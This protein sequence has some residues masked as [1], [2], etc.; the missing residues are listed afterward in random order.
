[1]RLSI[2]LFLFIWA[3]TCLCQTNIKQ[4]IPT[5]LS[6][7]IGTL[8]K[9]IDIPVSHYTGVPDVNIPIHTVRLGKYLAL[10][11]TLRY[12]MSGI[13]VDELASSVGLGWNLDA[14]GAII[15][16][17]Y[18]LN[19][20]QQNGWIRSQTNVS[21]TGLLREDFY[22]NE[23]VNY[24]A[25][26]YIFNTSVVNGHFD[27]QP[28]LFSYSIPGKS[29]KFFFTQQGKV[30]FM[31]FENSKVE[32][33]TSVNGF[34][35]FSIIDDKGVRYSFNTKE[36]IGFERNSGCSGMEYG[37][38]GQSFF[39]DK[40]V[41]PN[42]D[43]IEFQYEPYDY[44]SKI[45]FSETRANR[46]RGDNG[47][48]V[49]L[50]CKVEQNEIMHSFRLKSIKSSLGE[51]VN[52]SYSTSR[53]D[54]LGGKALNK[55]VSQINGQTINTFDFNY[56]YFLAS[57]SSSDTTLN[58]RLKLNSLVK[59]NTEKYTFGYNPLNLPHR[60]SVQQDYWGYYNGLLNSST[61]TLLPVDLNNNFISGAN[62]ETD[63]EAK[64]A[65]TL[66]RITYPTGGN[67]NF[68]LESNDI[69]NQFQMT[70]PEQQGMSFTPLSNELAVYELNVPNTARSFTASWDIS[71]SI[72]NASV[73]LEKG[74]TLIGTYIGES[75]G[76]VD[77]PN[78]APGIYQ[79]KFSYVTD[80]NDLSS[81]I[82]RINWIFDKTESVAEN[83]FVGGLRIKQINHDTN[84]GSPTI[85]KNYTY[86]LKG[87]A[88]S[89]GKT[90]YT[91]V[92][93]YKRYMPHT[94]STQPFCEYLQQSSNS[95]APLSLLSGGSAVYDYI[96]EFVSNNREQYGYTSYDYLNE[97]TVPTDSADL[98][99]DGIKFPFA[100][101]IVNSWLNGVLLR[102]IEYNYD[103]SQNKFSPIRSAE[104]EYKKQI[105]DG[106]NESFVR[107]ATIGVKISAS[108]NIFA[109]DYYYLYSS[110]FR[111]L[112]EKETVFSTQGS[113]ENVKEYF[114]DNPIHG[115]PNRIK[116]SSSN[117]MSITEMTLFP[118]DYSTGTVFI[119]N[120]T[121]KNLAAYPIERLKYFE[122][123]S[124][125][126]FIQGEVLQYKTGGQGL[127]DASYQLETQAP[128][129]I[130]AFK[131][132]NSA[133]GDPNII[134]TGSFVKDD[135]YKVNFQF[136]TYDSFGNLRES[137]D[138]SNALTVYLWG[139][140]G[141][142]PIAEIKN[143][144]YAEVVAVLTQPVIDNLNLTTHT[145][146]TMETLIKTAVDKLR[147]DPRLAKAMITS[148]TYKP[149]VG[150]TSKT[151]ARG[152]KETYKY[153]GMQRLQ[154][155]LDHLNYVTKAIDYHY[156]P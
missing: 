12:H 44:T 130:T 146:A 124:T 37:D 4:Y 58:K 66:Q 49:I 125:P 22:E 18:G 115:Y 145:E 54:L 151:D 139:Y 104:Y 97:G 79:V 23:T 99:M 103:K 154:A 121:S 114:Y 68:H 132:S 16:S 48:P 109:I 87:T 9:F 156:R 93:I 57:S 153:D 82:F 98:S 80:P 149:L 133:F 116:R 141:Q 65:S 36:T 26:W 74:G 78:L 53:A 92:Y 91:P 75:N 100:P 20:G 134:G 118:N 117:A 122:Q 89:S 76:F 32:F 14:G 38:S 143:A 69:Y 62:R 10:P 27:S 83:R 131:K 13:K 6:P 55:I 94:S 40:I 137:R 35:S 110:W 30:N 64:I 19:D 42:N 17:I 51:V 73:R 155:I 150:M 123:N 29:G 3:Q 105:G 142:Y 95:L 67:T 96:E 135:R 63:P 140:G 34:V 33:A 81:D 45:Q 120:M 85:I 28:D 43:Y 84:D 126:K 70:T 147:S 144:T 39:L 5:V 136:L 31:P 90:L 127:I 108:Y 113:A 112:R 7:D 129:S 59:N 148:Y 46:I 41:A 47:C 101:R 24:D 72:M 138:R 119:D 88:N 21:Q 60:L 71:K 1:M 15:H 86:K 77:I 11:I 61:G 25:P 102:K 52:F 2:L 50:P 56:G 111:L 152:I 107:G 106:A 8:S 128:I